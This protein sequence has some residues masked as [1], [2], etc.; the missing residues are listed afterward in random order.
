[1]FER[2][3]RT[4]PFS[5]LCLK[6]IGC[7][8]THNKT[9]FSMAGERATLQIHPKR[10]LRRY[11]VEGGKQMIDAACSA[12]AGVFDAIKLYPKDQTPVRIVAKTNALCAT[13]RPS[14]K[15]LEPERS[16]RCAF[17]QSQPL[18]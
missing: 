4:C 6:L 3:S 2:L 13:P 11:V 8:S 18:L 7:C 9:S 5:K 1:M 17:A 12:H 10:Q 15:A 14:K 16:S